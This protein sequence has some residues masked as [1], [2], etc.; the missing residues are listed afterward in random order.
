MTGQEKT[1]KLKYKLEKGQQEG[2]EHTKV[3]K[4]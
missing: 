4:Y 2:K 3:V 1:S